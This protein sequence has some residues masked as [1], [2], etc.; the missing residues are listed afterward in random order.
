M[1]YK[2]TLK[3]EIEMAW[4]NLERIFDEKEVLV[5]GYGSLLYSQG[6]AGRGMRH[7]PKPK[8]LIECQVKGYER[9]QY[10][11]VY[12]YG[13]ASNLKVGINF[14]G[15]VPN[16]K[17]RMNG[18]LVRIKTL[19]DWLALM[20]TEMLAGITTNY[21]YRG[22]DITKAVRGVKL[23]DNQVVHMVVNDPENKND[24][25]SFNAAPGYYTRVAKGVNEERSNKFKRIFYATGGL[26]VQQ[27]HAIYAEEYSARRRDRYYY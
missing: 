26:T 10:G 25:H 16:K 6:W 4:D 1:R 24:Y 22:V 19:D 27:S 8:D 15:V 17:A 23:K 18:V 5:L 13:R 11:L 21:N 3:N 9:G 14:Y 7:Q 20:S 2:R 12:S